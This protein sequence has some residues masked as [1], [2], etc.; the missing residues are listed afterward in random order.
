MVE[1]P[2]VTI[3][4]DGA[5][6]GNPG[7]GGWAALLLSGDQEQALSGGKKQTTNNQMELTAVCEALE[8]LKQPSRITLYTDSQYVKKGITEWIHG[9]IKKGWVNSKREPVANQDLW[10]RLLEARKQ[11]EVEFQWVRGHAGNRH[12]ER[13]D[14]LA[15]AEIAKLRGKTPEAETP[16]KP[17]V[18][19][20]SD[21][22]RVYITTSFD[23]KTKSAGWGIIIVTPDGVEQYSGGLR[24]VSEYQAALTAAIDAL[25]KLPVKTSVYIFID[26]ETVQKGASSWIKGWRSNGWLNSKKEPVAHKDLWQRLDKA[27]EGVTIQWKP[28]HIEAGSAQLEQSMTLAKQARLKL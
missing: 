16:S 3:F 26:N 18:V 21:A 12:N 7:V 20:P 24:N 6:S 14:R 19:I 25:A 9:W 4:T 10:Q 11:H 1:K 17:A 13:V 8:A 28:A 23:A 22:T 5:C 2:K 15:V 27:M